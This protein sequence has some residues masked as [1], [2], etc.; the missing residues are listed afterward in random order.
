MQSKAA[1]SLKI[2][3][4]LEAKMEE[5]KQRT[6]ISIFAIMDL[7][8]LQEAA[9]NQFHQVLCASTA[10]LTY[11]TSDVRVQRF[12]FKLLRPKKSLWP[13]LT[14]STCLQGILTKEKASAK[15][16]LVKSAPTTAE[17]LLLPQGVAPVSDCMANGRH[18]EI[19]QWKVGCRVGAAVLVVSRV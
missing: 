12:L 8:L 14:G 16:A 3:E 6:S 13:F 1:S 7:R 4:V 9:T 11:A 15:T 10:V 17:A 2:A 5:H 18:R 19:M